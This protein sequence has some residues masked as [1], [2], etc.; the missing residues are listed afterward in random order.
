MCIRDRALSDA[1][2]AH[3]Q[4]RQ[5]LLDAAA[6]IAEQEQEA[7][8]KDEAPATGSRN[9]AALYGVL[10]LAGLCG[11]AALRKKVF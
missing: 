10:L 5:D 3:V 1:D 4:N 6:K 11:A 2:K 7:N 8:K 9:G